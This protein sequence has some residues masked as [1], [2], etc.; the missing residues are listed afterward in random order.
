MKRYGIALLV[1]LLGCGVGAIDRGLEECIAENP[2]AQP[3][4]VGSTQGLAL[5]ASEPGGTPI[6]LP[7]PTAEDIA[8]HCR[9]GGGSGCN[10]RAFISK[11]AALC[12]GLDRGLAPGQRPWDVGLAYYQ[13]HKRVGWGILTVKQ[14]S[15]S[16]YSGESMVLDAISGAELDRGSYVATP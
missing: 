10:A 7:P 15:S 11:E 5:P 1:L 16:G 9:D 4:D 2:P 3:F 14:S 6:V 8:G 13:N 12:I